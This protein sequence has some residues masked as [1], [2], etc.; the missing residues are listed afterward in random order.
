MMIVE[1]I[2]DWFRAA[3]PNPTP[4]DVMVQIGCHFEEVSEMADAINDAELSSEA[5]SCAIF[6]KNSSAQYAKK[7]VADFQQLELLDALCDQI[8]TALGV[9]YMMGFDMVHALKEVNA[10][11]HSKFEN[12]KPIFNEQ[13]KI[14]KGEYYFK[15]NLVPYLKRKSK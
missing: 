11:N 4:K 2:L 3:K 9:G 6:F 14:M 12:G 1:S 7:A 15:P 10:S 8:V 5:N 13:G